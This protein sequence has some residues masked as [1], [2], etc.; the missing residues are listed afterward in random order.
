MS[1]FRGAR[2][3]VE[4]RYSTL[5]LLSEACT[6][7]TLGAGASG[8][9]VASLWAVSTNS[10]NSTALPKLPEWKSADKSLHIEPVL[11]APAPVKAQ[12]LVYKEV[13]TAA[14]TPKKAVKPVQQ[15]KL[16]VEAS[17][18]FV[19]ATY[20]KARRQ[21]V[22]LLDGYK[23]APALKVHRLVQ[24][25]KKPLPPLETRWV[26]V[27]RQ[28]TPR[29]PENNAHAIVVAATIETSQS[30]PAREEEVALPKVDKR[31]E[32]VR[33]EPPRIRSLEELALLE[34]PTIEQQPVQLASALPEAQTPQLAESVVDVDE[35]EVLQASPPEEKVISISLPRPLPVESEVVLPQKV[36]P[37]PSSIST[38][39][40]SMGSA[41][42]V[43]K[44]G[45]SNL[46]NIDY[47]EVEV[48]TEPVPG[49]IGSGR[50][51]F[52]RTAGYLETLTYLPISGHVEVPVFD[53]SVLSAAHWI[54][55]GQR[56]EEEPMTVGWVH[57]QLADGLEVTHVG[58]SEFTKRYLESS[59][60]LPARETEHAERSLVLKAKA[61]NA[62]EIS[63]RLYGMQETLSLV[64]PV[65][66]NKVTSLNLSEVRSLR[67]AG[68]VMGADPSPMGVPNLEVRTGFCKTRTDIQ[69]SFECDAYQLGQLPV[70]LEMQP[71]GSSI[72]F[73]TL[74]HTRRYYP[75][76][77]TRLIAQWVQEL[78][79]VDSNSGIFVG[80]FR[81]HANRAEALY[82]VTSLVSGLSEAE[83][84]ASESYSI[85]RRNTI[86]ISNTALDSEFPRAIAVN[87]QPGLHLFELE[88][89]RGAVNF[90]LLF[91]VQA[92]EIVYVDSFQ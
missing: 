8:L 39:E 72:H 54:V 76:P 45:Y 66:S 17:P 92:Q 86:E 1:R 19:F 60:L 15:R 4:Q 34:P 47:P 73:R 50:W 48:L 87:L 35:V 49:A 88:E 22:A 46:D 31:L 70:W 56:E 23:A 25:K 84:Q 78:G 32:W 7:L 52:V 53:E 13:T 61:G 91:S 20:L 62:L 42:V 21:Y 51:A 44:V 69:G 63:F 6:A 26:T 5:K 33:L 24:Q 18:E 85:S 27:K 74:A 64:V 28:S 65:L 58:E 41:Q 80:A 89:Q 38:V 68:K 67:I 40:P 12:P 14:K 36:T 75:L 30:A 77:S 90:G 16:K 37:P 11:R 59:R 83:A 79:G 3:S 82:P 2:V 29:P 71:A 55:S 43:A 10:L 57:L 9:L 81:S